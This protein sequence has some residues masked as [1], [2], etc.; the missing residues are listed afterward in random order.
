MPTIKLG[1]VGCGKAK[2]EQPCPA[3]QLY[4]S[5][6]FK[7]ALQ[8]AER[9]NDYVFIISAF[10]YLVCPDETI[11]PYDRQLG[12][13]DAEKNVWANCTSARVDDAVNR[14][15]RVF[16]NL[17]RN[18]IWITIYAGASYADPLQS[19]LIRMGFLHI[20]QP[21]KGLQI[22]ERLKWFK[23]QQHGN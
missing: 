19:H 16:R 18:D 3:R 17:C 21:L 2:A 15:K 13:T 10:H 12:S 11:Q 7:S 6:L 23:E 4:T 14:L 22:G 9:N 8:H 5:Q 20:L 1:L